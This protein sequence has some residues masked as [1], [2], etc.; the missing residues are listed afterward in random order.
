MTMI[1]GTLIPI[2]GN[3]DKGI[4]ESEQYTLEFIDDGILYHVV[5]EAGGIEANIV[6]IP[7]ASRI[8]IEVGAN[9]MDAFAKLGCKNVTVLDIRSKKDSEKEA[10]IR[11]IKNANCVMFSGGDQSKI[12]DKIGG[13]TIHQILSNRYNNEKGFVIAGTSAG[14]MA[15]ANEMIAGGSASEAFIKGAVTM[16][17][18]LNLIPELIIDTHFIKRGRFGRQSE[19]VAKHPNLIGLG[20][21][22]DTG[23]IIKNG[24][25]CTVIGSGMVIVFDGSKLT[26]NNEKI[27]EEGTPMTMANLIIHVLSNGDTYDIKNRKVSVLDIDADFI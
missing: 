9:Y 4:E 24:N 3:E 6:V 15:M 5:E 13:T 1:K 19:A 2:G 11:L 26:H 27:L 17:K 21:A 16:Y 14:A 18:G 7:T 22:E 12:T 8:P 10:S 23:M 20:L 25:D